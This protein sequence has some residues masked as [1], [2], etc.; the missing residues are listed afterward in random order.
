MERD[1]GYS[2]GIPFFEHHGDQKGERAK[3]L[4]PSTL[5]NEEHLDQKKRRQFQSSN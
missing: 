4:N 5:Q 3:A 1:R 2:F